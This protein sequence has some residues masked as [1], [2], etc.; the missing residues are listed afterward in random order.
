[1]SLFN[2]AN[3]CLHLN[4]FNRGMAMSFPNWFYLAALLISGKSFN[5]SYICLV[6][7]DNQSL[8]S[9]CSAAA[10]WYIA[11][12][13][14]PVDESVSG[15]LAEKLEK[16]SR[17]LTNKHSSSHDRR[18]LKKP[19]ANDS[20]DDTYNKY[21]CKSQTIQLWLKEFQDAKTIDIKNRVM[22]RRII[23][24]ILI[25]CSGSINEDGYGL[26][27]HYVATGTIFW[28]T[29]REHAGLTHRRW[30]YE[31]VG[32]CS[33]KEAVAGA[34]IVFNLTD[35]AEKMSD[36]ICETREIA[37]DFICKIK[38][39]VGRYLI[40]CVKRL[41][42]FEIDQNNDILIKDLHR[43]MLRWR[44]QGKDV[45]HGYKDLD[46]AIDVIASKLS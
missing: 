7:E 30:N 5:D 15:Q 38:L 27:L 17:T 41:L 20:G 39:K 4:S 33:R 18:K 43:R 32:K 11:W 1:M 10:A 3:V 42:Q 9:S 40:K 45:F 35:I 12:I 36:S 24:G 23:L 25:G 31:W 46:D 34:C 21:T 19:R 6:N 28:S 37:V 26:L 13:L 8:A 22:F 16:L 29:E 2:Y 44:H 14:D